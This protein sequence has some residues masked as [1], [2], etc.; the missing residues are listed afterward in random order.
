M[1]KVEVEYLPME[2]VRI[3][4]LDGAEGVVVSVRLW[5]ADVEYEV[6]YFNN[7]ERKVECFYGFDLEMADAE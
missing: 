6:R 2:R 3:K 1:P 4:P 5:L 7:G